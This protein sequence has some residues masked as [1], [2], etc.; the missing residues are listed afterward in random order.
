M[1][2][3][4]DS[5]AAVMWKA[6]WQGSLVVL[7]AWL[8][9]IVIPSMPAR[10]RC[11][12]WRLAILKFM[13]VLLL[14][15][16]VNLPLLPAPPVVNPMPEV[17]VQVVT[18]KMPVRTVD[19]VDFRPSSEIS[20]PSIPAMLASLWIIGVGWSMARLLVAWQ[21]ARRL[22]KHSRVIDDVPLI[23]QLALQARLYGLRTTPALL[24][25]EGNGSP[26]LI[27]LLRPA[28][29]I[30]GGTLRRLVPSEFSMVLGHELA[31]VQRGDLLWGLAAAA[32]RALFFFHPL[33]WLSQRRLNLAQE[34][35]ADELAILRQHHDP[36]SYGNLLVSVISKIGPSR[37]IPTM[38]LGTAGSVKSLTRR[39]VAMASFGRASRGLIIGSGILMAATFLLGIV[40]WRLVAAEPKVSEKQKEP[41]KVTLPAYRIEPP[42]VIG[43]EMPKVIP[44]PSYRATVQAVSGQ[45]LVGPD[46]TINLRQYGVVHINGKT[47]AETRIAIQNHLKQFLDSPQVAVDVLAYNSKVYYVITQRLPA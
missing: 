7:A 15:T 11:W 3:L 37:L 16:L 10:C 43:I 1:T 35:A 23:E 27:G 30:P 22:R 41:P 8:I 25:S 32:V 5:W 26:M 44:L 28:I 2:N 9:C 21:W 4:L 45:Y 39:L 13:V 46:G 18:L 31:H 20:L 38:S 14:P 12:L 47:V 17:A 34:V 29:V 24:E 6:C 42:D 19:K 36:V 40:P 33:V